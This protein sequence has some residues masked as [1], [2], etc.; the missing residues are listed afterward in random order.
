MVKT[1]V[2]LHYGIDTELKLSTDREI[3]AS[4]PGIIM[5]D[6]K[7]KKYTMIENRHTI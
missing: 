1:K 5:K 4:R 2:L 7:E 6:K 3:K